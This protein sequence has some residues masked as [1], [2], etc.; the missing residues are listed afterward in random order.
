MGMVVDALPSLS[1][2]PPGNIVLSPPRRPSG[3]PWRTTKK[4]ARY[5]HPEPKIPE[6]PIMP[7]PVTLPEPF[8][9][10][11]PCTYHTAPDPF[12]IWRSYSQGR[13]SFT[14]DIHFS[15]EQIVDIPELSPFPL[16]QESEDSPLLSWQDS[17]PKPV[18]YPFKN[19]TTYN[20][21]QWYHEGSNTKSISQ[22]NSLVKNVLQAPDFDVTH[23]DNFEASRE[24]KRLDSYISGTL[25]QPTT[26]SNDRGFFSG[27][28]K[29]G[30]VHL[31]LPCAT[32]KWASEADAP[33]FPVSFH[34]RKFLDVVKEA[35]FE[36][37]S[38]K[39]HLTPFR[40]YWQRNN[41]TPEERVYGEAYTSEFINAEYDR[42][43]E[44]L[45]S[46]GK[47]HL[48]IVIANV[49]IWSDATCLA[50]FGTASL[51]PI[52]VYVGNQSKYQR[53]CPD[54]FAAHHLAYLP[55]VCQ[56]YSSLKN[57]KLIHINVDSLVMI[58]MNFIKMNSENHQL[59]MSCRFYGVS[60][61]RQCG[62]SFLIAS[63]A[64]HMSMERSLNSTT[65]SSACS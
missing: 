41:S 33:K 23:L 16:P 55:K 40:S 20:L 51:W 28:W 12:G 11:T 63:S 44:D 65:R 6:P 57:A 30:T 49:M 7:D 3:L 32:K 18:Y 56:S 42:I 46:R 45:R 1:P 60:L 24:L 14:P 38:R 62:T 48:E 8:P 50:H 52:Y 29:V 27:D 59:Q 5:I 21:V 4:P 31:S 39:F 13:P 64:M 10:P 19:P 53:A 25:D 54:S 2:Y 47:E 43:S 17:K 35:F 26:T 37:E 34:Y 9:L 22:V 58:Y 36:E 61:S 15:P